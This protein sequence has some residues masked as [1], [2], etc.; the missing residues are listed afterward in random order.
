MRQIRNKTRRPYF[1]HI[2]SQKTLV[3]STLE[4]SIPTDIPK[5]K[6]GPVE[7]YIMHSDVIHVLVV[8]CDVCDVTVHSRCRATTVTTPQHL[9]IK[10][11]LWF[12]TVGYN[13]SQWISCLQLNYSVYNCTHN[14]YNN[15]ICLYLVWTIFYWLSGNCLSVLNNW[16]A[17]KQNILAAFHIHA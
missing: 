4:I 3:F 12:P 2:N 11:G 17:N 15:N 16:E 14:H 8:T 5:N 13:V 7:G 10:T 6:T 9:W 1:R